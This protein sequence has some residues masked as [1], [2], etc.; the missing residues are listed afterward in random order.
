M[1]TLTDAGSLPPG[2]KGPRREELQG[3]AG[4]PPAA[5][6]GSPRVSERNPLE[7]PSHP[8]PETL[9]FWT[10]PVP[11]EEGIVPRPGLVPGAGTQGHSTASHLSWLRAEGK[12]FTP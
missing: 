5:T 11:G 10:P 1:S 6:L 7:F 9:G 12:S 8:I 2:L 3:E 4:A